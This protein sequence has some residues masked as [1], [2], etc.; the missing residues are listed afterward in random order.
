MAGT[1]SAIYLHFVFSTHERRNLIDDEIRQGLHAYLGG[2]ARDEEASLIAA[3]GI[4]D[5]MHLLVHVPPKIAPSDL[6]RVFKSKSS[7]WMKENSDEKS[8]TWQAGFGVFSVSKSG[9]DEVTNYINRQREHH[10]KTDYKVSSSPS[11][12]NTKSNM[13][14]RR[15]G[16]RKSWR[17]SEATYA[18]T[19]AQN[20]GLRLT[21]G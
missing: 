7:A 14:R 16:G 8:F 3:G 11:L 21:V 20:L 9:I 5:H 4:E 12:K 18:P 6:M 15:F 19:G 17:F 1:H 13:M 2:I 10:A